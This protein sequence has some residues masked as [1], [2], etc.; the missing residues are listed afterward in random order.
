MAHCDNGRIEVRSKIQ[1]AYTI[2]GKD[3]AYT[4]QVLQLNLRLACRHASRVAQSRRRRNENSVVLYGGATLASKRDATC[5]RSFD[6][7]SVASRIDFL[8]GRSGS[9]VE[10]SIVILRSPRTVHQRRRR[11]S[12]RLQFARGMPLANWIESPF[13]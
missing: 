1:I 4:M 13:Y 5:E 12:R 2:H 8:S 10:N 3:S 9:R 6:R 11:W 7:R